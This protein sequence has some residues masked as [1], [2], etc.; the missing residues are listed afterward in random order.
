MNPQSGVLVGAVTEW[1]V[2]QP[3]SCQMLIQAQEDAMRLV[4]GMS[5]GVS[6]VGVGVIVVGVGVKA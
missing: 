1:G 6:H 5:C 3:V 2:P 4:C